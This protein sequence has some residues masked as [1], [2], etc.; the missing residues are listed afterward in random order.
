MPPLLSS[1]ILETQINNCDMFIL[2]RY[3]A[4]TINYFTQNQQFIITEKVLS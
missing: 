1:E 2:I 3:M 4:Y